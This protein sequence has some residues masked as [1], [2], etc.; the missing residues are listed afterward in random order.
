MSGCDPRLTS[1]TKGTESAIEHATTVVRLFSGWADSPI[2]FSGPIAYA[3]TRLDADL[4]AD[5]RAWDDGYYASLNSD[6]EWA[7]PDDAAAYYKTGAQ[8]AR[9]LAG[10]IGDEFQVQHNLPDKKSRVRARG[11]ALNPDA[12]AAFRE[13][14]QRA[15]ADHAQ[16]REA[17]QRARSNGDVLYWSAN[18]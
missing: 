12:A 17:V 18:P 5:L 10:Q 4:V 7:N 9:R 14:A 16:I 6:Y 15:R 13:L 3:D 11:P 2:W 8:L 1:V